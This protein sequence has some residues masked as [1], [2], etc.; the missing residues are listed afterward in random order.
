MTKAQLMAMLFAPTPRKPVTVEGVTGHVS[1]VQREDGSGRSFNV[2]L[3][4]KDGQKT[5]YVRTV[6]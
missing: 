2:T 6:A 3:D 4:T 5:V 1:A